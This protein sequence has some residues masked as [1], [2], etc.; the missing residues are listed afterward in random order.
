MIR[1]EAV[2][3]SYRRA[4]ATHVLEQGRLSDWEAAKALGHITTQI[5]TQPR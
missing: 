5:H 4:W 2:P 3:Y 1:E